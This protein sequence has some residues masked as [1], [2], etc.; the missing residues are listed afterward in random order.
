MRTSLSRADTGAGACEI[1]LA[2]SARIAGAIG[3]SEKMNA[4][5]VSQGTAVRI[6]R[7]TAA[8]AEALAEFGARTFFETFAA[9]NTPED[10]R[11][12]PGVG[13][14][15]GPAA[16]RNRRT[17]RS[18]RCWRA[19][20]DGALAGFAQ[21]RV[22][23]RRPAGIA[24]RTARGAQTLLRRQALAGPGPGAH[25]HGG[26]RAGSARGARRARVVAGRLGAQRARA[27]VLPQVRLPQGG[28]ADFRRRHGSADRSR[29]AARAR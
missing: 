23:A 11:A 16:R 22:G 24:A 28:D 25:A 17:R 3:G 29:D 27:G 18:I 2:E 14:A 7:A 21:L 5:V 10:M 20:S 6:R 19:T 8:D 15:P 9:D 12:A 26:R 1:L 13:L 4:D